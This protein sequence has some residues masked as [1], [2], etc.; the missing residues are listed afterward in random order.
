MGT[1]QEKT[2]V[3]LMVRTLEE[4]GYAVTRKP[5]VISVR[6]GEVTVYRAVEKSPGGPWLV[7]TREGPSI[8]WK[9]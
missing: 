2:V 3:D 8:S 4:S 1:C 6:D 5:G 7:T 9:E